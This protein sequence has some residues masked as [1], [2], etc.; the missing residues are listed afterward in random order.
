MAEH[1]KFSNRRA[2]VDVRCKDLEAEKSGLEQELSQQ[3]SRKRHF[4][5]NIRSEFL[6]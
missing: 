5:D 4:D 2:D 1:T 6:R 3:A